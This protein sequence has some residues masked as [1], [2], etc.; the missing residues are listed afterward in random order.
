MRPAGQPKR[1]RRIAAGTSESAGHQSL[2][3]QTKQNISSTTIRCQNEVTESL[4]T[5]STCKLFKSTISTTFVV[6]S[7]SSSDQQIQVVMASD[8]YRDWRRK[9][10]EFY[11]DSFD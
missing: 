4:E 2:P 1:I 6:E 9:A 5:L 8:Y 3:P 11:H 10:V 7:P